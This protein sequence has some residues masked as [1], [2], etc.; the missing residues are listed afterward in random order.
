M[1]AVDAD[2][3]AI[4]Q[5]VD[6]PYAE[7]AKGFTA[8]RDGDVIMAK[9][10]PCMENG[11]AAIARGLTNSL[12]FG[13]TEFHV[14]RPTDR[15][16]A[17]YVYCFIRQESFRQAAE[18]E[19]TGSVGQKRVPAD[20]IENAEIPLPP[21]AEQERIVEAIERLT[22]RVDA[23]RA[24]LAAVPAI[25]KRFR[26]A[27]L[28]AA[29]SGRLTEDW[30]EAQRRGETAADLLRLI[31]E[32]RQR[33]IAAGKRRKIRDAEEEQAQVDVQAATWDTPDT[34]TWCR[35]SDLLHYERSAA[36]GVLQPGADLPDG[37]P[38]VRVCDL[39]NGTVST[40][41]IKRIAAPI[42]A[43]YPRTRLHGREVL[44][45]L[46][47][48]IGRTAVV[49]MELAGANV[50]RAVGVLPLCPHAI[51]EYVRMAL[52]VPAKNTELNDLAREVAR[53]TLNLGLLKAVQVPLPPAAE[54]AEIVRRVES[55]MKL[56]DAIERRVGAAHARADKL[57]Q[58]VLA[59]A[60]RG[61][62]VPAAADSDTANA[63]PITRSVVWRFE[64]FAAIQAEI[65]RRF[66]N[67]A[68]LGRKKLFKLSYLAAALANAKTERPLKQDAAGPY[69]GKL[70]SD[71]EAHAASQK[72]FTANKVARD[73]GEAHYRTG[74]KA[75]EVMT[76]SK[77]LLGSQWTNFEALLA[78][79]KHWDSK[80]A[81]LHAT[82]HAAWNGL[83]AASKTAPESAIVEVFF[84]WSKEKTKFSASQVRGAIATLRK[85]GLEPK[86]S[87]PVVAGVGEGNLF[88]E[89]SP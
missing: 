29:C 39:E 55:L 21:L 35:I 19:M 56:A 51:P 23:A 52:D 64:D 45:T 40:R 8:F 59:K 65:V 68:T 31:A 5:P 26:Q 62:L 18:M 25:L 34:W 37:I 73:P 22:A 1:P 13:S 85:L 58:S 43:Q 38:F 16:L 78:A 61:E 15:V 6:R 53:K 87:G 50:A 76:T 83:L 41:A 88:S 75:S 36:Y 80:A 66:P 7:V 82:T 12:G 33:M 24:R 10:T 84:S 30:R 32:E 72:W 77:A 11:K 81:E 67:D 14:L 79:A 54:Q 63:Q 20:F 28:A 60:F 69:D 4:T 44:V 2:A 70:Q 3:G 48:T 47:G 42:D 46:V 89:S 86:G 57:T 49:Q 74:T 71:A 27:V 17:E 9:I